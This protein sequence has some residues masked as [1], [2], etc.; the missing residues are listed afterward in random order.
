MAV[1]TS[2][3]PPKHT[4]WR[5]N[6]CSPHFGLSR[7]LDG[8]K[9]EDEEETPPEVSGLQNKLLLLLLQSD[10]A[11]RCDLVAGMA[12]MGHLL[13]HHLVKCA[14]V[15]RVTICGSARCWLPQ[16]V[17][18]FP[19]CL[20]RSLPLPSSC[21]CQISLCVSSICLSLCPLVRSLPLP[22]SCL[23]ACNS[24][25][26]ALNLIVRAYVCLPLCRLVRSLLLPSS[27]QCRELTA[28][29]ATC[30]ASTA[31]WCC[32][33]MTAHSPHSTAGE[34]SCG[35][36]AWFAGL[37]CLMCQAVISVCTSRHCGAARR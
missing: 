26:P 9:V 28:A 21:Q 37:F 4:L 10:A 6:L 18:L 36:C 22:S 17:R 34:R 24:V 11:T 7:A 20:V 13:K 33:T 32:W 12:S 35:R 29:T 1:A 2:G 3:I 19:C 23:A 30:G 25:R 27:C 14:V 8:S 5:T 16:S 31:L 15:R